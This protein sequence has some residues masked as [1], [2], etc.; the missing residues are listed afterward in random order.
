[1]KQFFNNIGVSIG[2]PDVSSMVIV[3]DQFMF[4]FLN[5]PIYDFINFFFL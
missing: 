4:V 1:M 5:D 3:Y 2:D